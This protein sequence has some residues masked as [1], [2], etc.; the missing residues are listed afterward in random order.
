MEKHIFKACEATKRIISVAHLG[1]A[2]DQ[3]IHCDKK[4]T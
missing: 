3:Y 2:R 4:Y 1:M